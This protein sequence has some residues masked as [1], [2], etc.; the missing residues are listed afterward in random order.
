MAAPT[1]PFIG[2]KISLISNAEIRYEG[3]L[4]TINTEE[5]TIAL[6]HVRSFGTEGR[7]HP[8]V[9]KS[10]E[11]YHFI[12][13]R[14]K[15]IKELN[16][17]SSPSAAISADPAIVKVDKS[18]PKGKGKGRQEWREPQQLSWWDRTVAP[19]LKG[20]GKKGGG[21]GAGKA[22]A[23]PAKG[24]KGAGK[25]KKV[26]EPK[27]AKGKGKGKGKDA[28]PSPA[29]GKGKGKA[30][31]PAKAAPAKAAPAKGKGKAAPEP[32]KAKGA[33]KGKA[34]KPT[35]GK[36]KGKAEPAKPAKGKGKGK[37]DKPEKPKR[38][39]RPGSGAPVGVGIPKEGGEKVGT[40]FDMVGA[41]E[42]FKKEAGDSSAELGYSKSKGFFDSISREAAQGKKDAETIRS[43]RAAQRQLDRDTF[44]DAALKRPF[45]RR[46]GRFG[47]G[48]R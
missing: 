3:T 23:A 12:I 21:K 15:D 20:K 34:E 37:A 7:R 10:N 45:G 2:S 14:G 40:D 25:G 32:K 22:A 28:S 31:A 39:A 4:Y 9:P 26:E 19:T 29:K 24:A 36:G 41:N 44:G 42:K 30:A 6:Q 35:K 17:L 46:G 27:P 33:A 5:S 8:E 38:R 1:L 48:K 16:V 47:R 13:F 11:T 43:E 18:P